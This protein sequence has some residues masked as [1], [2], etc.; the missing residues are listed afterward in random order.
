MADEQEQ[1]DAYFCRVRT[2]DA[3][4]VP[5]YCT[6]N[7]DEATER[8]RAYKRAVNTIAAAIGL[9]YR[10][11]ATSQILDEATFKLTAI[12]AFTLGNA[13]ASALPEV[14]RELLTAPSFKFFFERFDDIEQA[15]KELAKS[16]VGVVPVFTP[17]NTMTRSSSTWNASPLLVGGAVAL[18]VAT[19]VLIYTVT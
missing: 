9:P 16:D 8:F 5:A 17:A 18:V 11:D 13:D 10:L 3:D 1:R 12:V 2:S 14:L 15:M 6:P 19:S 4:G 7:T